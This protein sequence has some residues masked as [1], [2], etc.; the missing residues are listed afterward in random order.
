M[1]WKLF[2]STFYRSSWILCLSCP[3]K[4]VFQQFHENIGPAILATWYWVQSPCQ[5]D[6]KPWKFFL[7]LSKYRAYANAWLRSYLRMTIH[8]CKSKFSEKVTFIPYWKGYGM[9]TSL[10]LPIRSRDARETPGDN[11]NGGVFTSL[12]LS[13]SFL[14]TS[15]DRHTSEWHSWSSIRFHP[16]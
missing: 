5:L 13:F 16:S 1:V 15:A 3:W 8:H 9:L 6:S 2:Q 11:H 10:G 12:Y 14:N 4:L 7:R